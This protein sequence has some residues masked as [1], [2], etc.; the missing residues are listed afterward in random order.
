MATIVSTKLC[1]QRTM[2]ICAFFLYCCFHFHF[3]FPLPLAFVFT[4]VFGSIYSHA[5]E[6]EC[7]PPKKIADTPLCVLCM[8]FF[9]FMKNSI[10]V[11]FK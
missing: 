4:E 7:L 11:I 8:L 6:N 2:W 1:L 5:F 3:H 10:Y 9:M